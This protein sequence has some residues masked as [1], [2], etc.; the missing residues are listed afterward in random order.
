MTL[1][2]SSSSSS[3]SR[4]T[5]SEQKRPDNKRKRR[6]RPGLDLSKILYTGRTRKPT[7]R[8]GFVPDYSSDDETAKAARRPTKKRA[9]SRIIPSSEEEEAV[10]EHDT[11][12]EQTAS[13]SDCYFESGDENGL[14]IMAS[15]RPPEARVSDERDEEIEKVTTAQEDFENGDYWNPDQLGGARDKSYSRSA[16]F[17]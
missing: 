6:E 4:I 9:V 8:E 7:V 12:S 1:P 15:S 10:P 13:E 5:A 17:Y 3:G 2:T 11:D 16:E 14:R